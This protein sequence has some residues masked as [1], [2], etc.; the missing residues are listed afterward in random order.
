MK[1]TFTTWLLAAILLTFTACKKGDTGSPG[2]N[3][4]NGANGNANV[5]SMTATISTNQW[6]LNGNEYDITINDAAITQSI[7]TTGSIQLFVSANGTT[8]TALPFSIMDRE[9][10]FQYSVG[11]VTIGYTT[12]TGVSPTSAPNNDQFKIIAITASARAANPS[13]NWNDY[14]QVKGLVE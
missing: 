11:L 10:N 14:N 6:T 5:Q 9:F 3:G 1:T 12:G 2:T 13:V 4:T 8:W 7:V